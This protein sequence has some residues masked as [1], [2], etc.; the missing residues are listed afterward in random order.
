MW[1]NSISALILGV[2]LRVSGVYDAYG[3]KWTWLL[4]IVTG[5]VTLPWALW[6]ERRER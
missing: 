1:W 5:I 4:L 2:V 6:R 3:W